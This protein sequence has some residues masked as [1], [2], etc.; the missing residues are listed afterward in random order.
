MPGIMFALR[1]VPHEST[2]FS[3]AELVYG[4]SLR[5]AQGMMKYVWEAI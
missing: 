1:A 2:G 4:G 3:A 5:S